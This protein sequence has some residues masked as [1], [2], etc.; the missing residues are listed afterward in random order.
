MNIVE[1][2]SR[3][4]QVS[5]DFSQPISHQPRIYD[6]GQLHLFPE[7]LMP[8]HEYRSGG[9]GRPNRN[10][11]LAHSQCKSCQRVLRNDFFYTPPSM[12]RRNVVFSH[13]L[14]CAKANNT[15]RYSEKSHTMRSRNEHI[16]RY[17]APICLL[18]GFDQ[19]VSAMDFHSLA[20]AD[21]GAAF[22]KEKEVAALIAAVAHTPDAY[23][24]ER[25]LREAS[26]C[27]PLCSNCH[28]M[29]HA[30]ILDA[31]HY[32]NQVNYQLIS[33]MELINDGE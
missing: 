32:V 11:T 1:F 14:T 29:V 5:F 24:A 22:K 10:Q 23:Q 25:L 12:M 6:Q 18:C 15:K 4:P 33:F 21:E 19:H 16:W 30:K 9:R 7:A 26:Q 17:L 28:R 8:S 3:W 27:I 2:S 13:C 20:I 31:S